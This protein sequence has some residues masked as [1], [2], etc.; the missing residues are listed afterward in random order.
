MAP[1]ASKKCG[2]LPPDHQQIGCCARNGINSEPVPG[3]I[4]QQRR[5][6]EGGSST[7]QIRRTQMKVSRS[8]FLSISVGLALLGLLVL[9]IPVSGFASEPHI[10][11]NGANSTSWQNLGNQSTYTFRY[12]ANCGSHTSNTTLWKLTVYNHNITGSPP[13]CSDTNNG[14]GYPVPPY[15]RD[16]Q[17]SGLPTGAT[18]KIRVVIDYKAIGSNSWMIHTD[19]FKN[20]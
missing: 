4:S 17:C 16:K 15:Y 13:I 10:C 9:G 19:Y 5:H 7:R 12:H 20:Y 11:I 2:L 3:S 8:L 14:A 18:A 1:Q 6:S